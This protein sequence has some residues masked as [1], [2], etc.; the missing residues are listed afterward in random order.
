MPREHWLLSNSLHG[1]FFGTACLPDPLDTL[2]QTD[3]IGLKLVPAPA[4]DEDSGEVGPVDQLAPEGYT[5]LWEVV[6]DD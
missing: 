4:D 5:P 2:R 3:I 1:S 6:C